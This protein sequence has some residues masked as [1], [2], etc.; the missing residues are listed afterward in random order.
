[1][2]LGGNNRS[3]MHTY[4]HAT[5]GNKL[6]FLRFQGYTDEGIGGKTRKEWIAESGMD[7]CSV[8]FP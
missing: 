4:L 7:A 8:G 5:N 2:G 1:M 3:S 6:S